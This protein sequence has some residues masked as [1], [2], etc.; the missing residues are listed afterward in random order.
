[1]TVLAPVPGDVVVDGT[2]GGG[3]HAAALLERIGASGRYIGI[4]ADADA[5]ERVRRLPIGGDPRLTLVCGNARDLVAHLAVCGVREASKVLF[6]LGLS[7]D[8]LTPPEGVVGRGFS[9]TRD[10]PLLMTLAAHPGAEELTARDVVNTW[11]E[12]TLADI[13]FGFGEEPRAR[14]IARAIVAA[15]DQV[16]IETSR[17]L[18]AI[19]ERAVGRR[20]AHHPATRTFQAI[21]IAVNSELDTLEAMLAASFRVLAHGGRLAVISF[22]SLE[23]RVVKHRF[24]AWEAAG[25]G[26]V[27]TKRAIVP[28]DAECRANRRARSAKLRCF[29]KRVAS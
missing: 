16:P 20:G 25:Q 15:R 5:L 2:L 18:A 11:G 22:H 13:I 4:D 7:S 28:S 9:F 29:E 24:R 21:R 6:D 27:V 14:R 23:D 26:V 17:D 19:V 12:E 8:Q 3:G 10:E 1:M